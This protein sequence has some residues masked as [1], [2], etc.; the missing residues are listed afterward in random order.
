MPFKFINSKGGPFENFIVLLDEKIENTIQLE[1]QQRKTK[2]IGSLINS[3]AT[4][5]ILG[6]LKDYDLLMDPELEIK[7]QMFGC[8]QNAEH[9]IRNSKKGL[10]EQ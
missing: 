8:R 5:W 10:R 2:E 1:H 9:H 4:I 7:R 3:K 6:I